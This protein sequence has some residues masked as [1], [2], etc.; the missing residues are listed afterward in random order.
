MSAEASTG[1]APVSA[2][3]TGGGVVSSVDRGD[4]SLE[5]TLTG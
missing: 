1:N 4:E 5:A 3:G 2:G